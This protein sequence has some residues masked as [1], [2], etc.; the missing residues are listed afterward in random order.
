MTVAPA[1]SCL[2]NNCPIATEGECLEGFENGLGCPNLQM[3]VDASAGDSADQSL[4]RGDGVN[5]D[6]D[7]AVLSRPQ[8]LVNIRG[9]AALTL[10]E[11]E[12]L[13]SAAP[14]RVILVAGEFESG[15]TTLAV[16]IY[17]QF[18]RGP[19]ADCIFGGSRTLRAFDVFQ[20]PSRASS[21][22]ERSTTRATREEGMRLLHLRLLR[23]GRVQNLF[24]SDVRGEYFENVIDGAGADAE[25]PLAARADLCVL[26]IDGRTLSDLATRQN[27]MSRA[28]LL[29]GGLTEPGGIQ[30]PCRLILA[31]TKSD[32][33][34]EETS[35]WVKE[36]LHKLRTRGEERGV[37][38][39]TTLVAARPDDI[40]Q[41]QGLE[42]LFD[43]MLPAP[44]PFIQPQFDA[45][46]KDR[47]FWNLPK[48]L[49]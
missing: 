16:Q 36:Q 33:L 40:G 3:N 2:Q 49:S 31:V 46:P 6:E 26:V 4:D 35:K 38:T 32:L 25:I 18:L 10:P 24:I 39:S 9:D 20:Q 44:E 41:A 42:Q 11:A 14:S 48:V 27:A 12:E 19:F 13:A 28:R 34:D 15:K 7:D 8:T 22:R 47:V 45:A 5:E 17:A 30:S 1:R 37:H 29:L 43:R 23:Q 21:G